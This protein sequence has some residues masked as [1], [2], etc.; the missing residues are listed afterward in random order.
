MASLQ[1]LMKGAWLLSGGEGRVTPLLLPMKGAGFP[2]GV[3]GWTDME[4]VDRD[5]PSMGRLVLG[6]TM[7]LG[8]HRARP[9]QLKGS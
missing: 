3:E 1:C 5:P 6:S 2:C 9:R 7:Q 8:G 4:V